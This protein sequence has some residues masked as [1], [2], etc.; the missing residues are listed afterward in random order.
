[1][2]I[3]CYCF[4]SFAQDY[5]LLSESGSKKMTRSTK[6]KENPNTNRQTILGCECETPF[7]PNRS[8][9][10]NRVFLPLWCN[11]ALAEVAIKRLKQRHD[12]NRGR[13]KGPLS[14]FSIPLYAKAFSYFE[15][16]QQLLLPFLCIDVNNGDICCNEAHKARLGG[17]PGADPQV[18]FQ[19]CGDSFNLQSFHYV[20][21]GTSD[22]IM[23]NLVHLMLIRQALEKAVFTFSLS[24]SAGLASI[25]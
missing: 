14:R 5:C 15:T 22:K 1:M 8:P 7:A 25:R 20:V 17:A 13:K 9:L 3:A 21:S 6:E 2:V 10:R 16:Q 19:T 11:V 18:T 24:Q 23:I 4:H 12:C